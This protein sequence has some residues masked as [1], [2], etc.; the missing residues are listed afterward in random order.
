M[1]IYSVEGFFPEAVCHRA[2]QLCTV[3]ATSP[4]LAAKRGLRQLL[5]RPGLK[6]KQLRT[7]Q[8]TIRFV[9]K[10]RTDEA[11]QPPAKE[12]HVDL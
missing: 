3:E 11:E 8:L 2:N 5:S 9:Q 4:E 12:P 6:G 7:Y 10:K 1:N